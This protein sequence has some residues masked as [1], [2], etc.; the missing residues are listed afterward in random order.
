MLDLDL[1]E[2]SAT[3]VGDAGR[4][5]IPGGWSQLH[6]DEPVRAV[7]PVLRGYGLGDNAHGKDRGDEQNEDPTHR[8]SSFDGAPGTWRVI[9]PPSVVAK[10]RAV[11]R[12]APAMHAILRQ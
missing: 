9:S 4:S 10:C 3:K 8:S 2:L 11:E 7:R 12:F 6:G 1:R 5:W